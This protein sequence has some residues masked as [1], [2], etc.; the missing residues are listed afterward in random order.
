MAAATAV[1]SPMAVRWSA[2][3]PVRRRFEPTGLRPCSMLV[4]QRP[5]NM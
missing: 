3:R 4:R 2:V 5:S 1:K